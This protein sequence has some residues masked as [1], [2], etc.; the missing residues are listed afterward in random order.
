MSIND[1][2][3]LSTAFSQTGSEVSFQFASQSSSEFYETNASGIAVVEDSMLGLAIQFL[4]KD[5]YIEV[6]HPNLQLAGDFSVGGWFK[7][8]A[9]AN[10]VR[11][12]GKGINSAG[13]ESF[14]LWA[15]PTNDTWWV[16]QQGTIPQAATSSS[17]R[18]IVD[19]LWYHVMMVRLA[20]TLTLYYNMEILAQV[21]GLNGNPQSDALPLRIGYNGE[22]DGFVGEMAHLRLYNRA[23][24][25]AEVQEV[26]HAAGVSMLVPAVSLPVHQ[27]E[28]LPGGDFI[29]THPIEFALFDQNKHYALYID[30]NPLGQPLEFDVHNISDRDIEFRN[31]NGSTASTANY[32]FELQFRKGVLSANTLERLRAAQTPND[33]IENS[34]SWDLFVPEEQPFG[35]HLSLYLLYTGDRTWPASSRR[36]LRLT[37]INADASGG[38]RGTQVVMVPNQLA[39][40]GSDVPITGSRTQ[41]LSIINHSGLM[42][43]PLHVGFKGS[44]QVVNINEVESKLTLQ[45]VNT[46]RL[47]QSH[48]EIPPITLDAAEDD[49]V[50]SR[51]ILEFDTQS[52]DEE[53]S[54]ALARASE[55]NL[56]ISVGLKR[57]GQTA[58]AD[59]IHF[60]V[61]ANTQGISPQWQITAQQDTVLD[62]GDTVEIV[63]A[64]IRSSLPTGPTNLYLHYDHISGYQDGRFVLPVFKSPLLF[65]DGN[66]SVGRAD[67]SAKLFIE[68]RSG[69][70]LRVEPDPGEAVYI[71]RFSQNSLEFNYA[72]GQAINSTAN[73][74]LN[75]D[76]DNTEEGHVRYIDFRANGAGFD[77][78]QRLMQIM[79]GGQVA[80][81]TQTW[82]VPNYKMAPG[83]LTLG[84]I[85]QNYG[86]GT[87]WND[88]NTAGL[89]LECGANTEIAVHDAGTRVI[90]LMY[91]EGDNVN[92]ITIG[93]NMGWG[94]TKVKLADNL[95]IDKANLNEVAL[96]LTGSGLGWGSGMSF[97]NTG[98]G[99]KSY[100]IYAG[101]TGK[102][103]FADMNNSVDRLLIDQNGNVGVGTN[104]PLQRLTV[105]GGHLQIDPNMVMGHNPNDRFSYD[106]KFM[107]HYTMGWFND[108]WNP[109]GSTA[110][111][112]GW[113]GIK[114]FTGGSPRMWMDMWGNI[115]YVGNL[116][117]AS[118]REIKDDIVALSREEALQTLDRLQPV[119][120]RLKADD[121]QQLHLGF[122][123]E[124]TPL[125]IQSYDKKGVVHDNIVAVLTAVVKEQ[126]AAINSLNT[127]MNQMTE[128]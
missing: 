62:P 85:H 109:D 43:I 92:Q 124:D 56:T 25:G 103:H 107:G 23:L 50:G 99:G 128:M 114:F 118:S 3:I 117:K 63:I 16:G 28:A 110:W 90:S 21:S 116:V 106:G 41:H 20:D 35:D 42:E 94:T 33:M 27:L 22:Y 34:E 12:V 97:H 115:T 80:I 67:P 70:A 68:A 17:E 78:G 32:H 120:Y 66:V 30:N 6:A 84:N 7:F 102:F 95:T 13:T 26:I 86:G 58:V 15:Y 31:S 81:G 5:S 18:E 52:D 72:S 98:P 121:T 113:A 36:Q 39:F 24:S 59:D 101:I 108:G 61:V 60:N 100:G 2:L 14:G 10:W 51:L 82:A 65:A 75:I 9:E 45:I 47:A 1:G 46:R 48:S 96:T 53:K 87:L 49:V 89:L 111:L 69:L 126:Q 127:R 71:G 29:K 79:D 93:R 55:L 44:N 91:Y 19:G 37:G 74:S 64:G 8:S 4:N 125:L 77:A 119:S 104:A 122:I 40:V 38:A 54:W 76:T 83:S 88:G 73:I 112:S 123:A 105:S 57:R 11:L